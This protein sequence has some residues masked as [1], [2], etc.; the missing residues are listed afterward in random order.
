MSAFAANSEVGKL[1]KVMVH[2]PGLEHT[3]L[4][5]DNCGALLFDD[6]I[7]V[8]KAKLEHDAFAE[9]MREHDVEVFYAEALLAEALEVP[10]GREWVVEQVLNERQIGV[11][12]AERARDV[13]AQMSA[14][15]LADY[16][17]GGFTKADAEQGGGLFYDSLDPAD[18]LLPP[19]PNF[20]FQRDPS[21]WIYG[22]VTVNPMTKPARRPETAYVEAIYRFHPMFQVDGGVRFWFGGVEEQWGR[23][24]I[25][26]GDVQ[27]IGNGA[28]MIGMGE[29][30]TPQA[31]G[32]LARTLFAARA[33]TE[34][35]AVQLPPSRSY[36]HLDTVITMVDR[37]AVTLY[38]HVVN[39]DVRVW[40]LTPASDDGAFDLTRR[41]GDLV[42]EMTRVLELDAMRVI[43][44]GGDRF[45]QDR[46]QW[47]DGNNVVALEP[48]V[49]IAYQ[50]NEGTNT[51]LRKAGIEVIEIDG[52]ELGRGRG[53]G[54]CMTCPLLRDPA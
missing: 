9:V 4:T 3:R 49:V 37:D 1:R 48:G 10:A 31:V 47:D 22:G 18:V 11:A 7:W 6:V 51:L 33:A 23:C 29:R 53:G 45:E 8:R 27:P 25:E 36:M 30:T 12:L 19:L 13:A 54:H 40:S 24:T 28:V 35:L 2:R 46:E 20:L 21:C 34:V 52:S 42:Q 14:T 38:P 43:K 5:P 17:I 41:T 16:L 44:T 39:E 26:G 50:R 15:E 32:I